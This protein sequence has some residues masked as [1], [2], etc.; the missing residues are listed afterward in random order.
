MVLDGISGKGR[1]YWADTGWLDKLFLTIPRVVGIC[2]SIIPALHTR[3]LHLGEIKVPTDA[4]II[5]KKKQRYISG[6]YN[7]SFF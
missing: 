5:C 4:I 2:T 7:F 6:S 1:D 3:K